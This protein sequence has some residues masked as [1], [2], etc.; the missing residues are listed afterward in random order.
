MEKKKKGK[1][2]QTPPPPQ[3]FT[4]FVLVSKESFI[5]NLLLQ[6]TGQNVLKAAPD[7]A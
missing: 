1:K 6:E 3:V 4:S 7:L 2:S 5:Y